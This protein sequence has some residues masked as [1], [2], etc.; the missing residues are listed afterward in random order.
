MAPKAT[1]TLARLG[2]SHPPTFLPLG[3]FIF[4]RVELYQGLALKCPLG[5]IFKVEVLEEMG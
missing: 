2:P 1:V 5:F 4:H 3:P